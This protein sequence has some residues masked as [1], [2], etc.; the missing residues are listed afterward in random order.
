MKFFRKRKNKKG[1][2]LIELIVVLAIL[3]VILAIAV[4]RYTG[5]QAAAQEK[6]DRASAALI[7]SSAR[8]MEANENLGDGGVIA[9]LGDAEGDLDVTA[10][11]IESVIVYY[12]KD[13]AP[14]SD[15][16]AFILSFSEGSYVVTYG[17]TTFTEGDSVN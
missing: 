5:L 9:E 14:E 2:T 13:S 11:G 10:E 7:I 8:L 15:G 3:G 1:F 17:T 6:A 12:D 16:T 4:P